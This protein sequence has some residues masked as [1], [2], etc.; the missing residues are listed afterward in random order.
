MSQS[1]TL[2]NQG[3]KVIAIVDP[4][5][6]LYGC[7]QMQ[8]TALLHAAWR[9]CTPTKLVSRASLSIHSWWSPPWPPALG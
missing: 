8:V 2:S 1:N 9:A 6:G 3:A 4:C 7:W 5:A